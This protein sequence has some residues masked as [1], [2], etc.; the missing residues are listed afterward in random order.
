MSS[1][2]VLPI[3]PMNQAQP[4]RGLTWAVT[5]SDE[6]RTLNQQSDNGKM[7]LFPRWSNNIHHWE[8]IWNYIN[9]GASCS[10]L[11]IQP[12]NAPW[13]DFQLLKGLRNWVKG[14]GGVFLY[15]PP[16][17]SVVSQLLAP[18]DANL[19]SELIY[20]IGAFPVPNSGAAGPFTISTVQVLNNLL[21]IATAGGIPA[22]GA[23]ITFT[24]VG[25]ATFLN[26]QSVSV[27]YSAGST[28]YAA[29]QHANYGGAGDTGTA[30]ITGFMQPVT[31]SVQYQT[32]LTLYQAGT[33]IS[34]GNYTVFGPSTVAPYQGYTIQFNFTPTSPI[35][36][37]FTLAYLA[38]FEDDSISYDNF[39]YNYWALKSLKVKQFRL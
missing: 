3:V 7:A 2:P 15:N 13:T 29:F 17:A 25:T 1:Y 18:P 9:D 16:Y 26:N 23:N 28:F 30:T 37:S 38:M 10:Q 39:M 11:P 6:F 21:K 12:G 8:F 5:E 35:T 14:S 24:G 22:P 36:A 19:N 34:T 27:L 33:L 20:S 4:I 31:E 32:G